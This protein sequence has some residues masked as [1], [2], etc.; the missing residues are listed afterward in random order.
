MIQLHKYDT[1]VSEIILHF[2]RECNFY[3][4]CC[5]LCSSVILKL[6]NTGMYLFDNV[7]DLIHDKGSLEKYT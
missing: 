5:C 1:G 4:F 2:I 3:T 7:A 6:K